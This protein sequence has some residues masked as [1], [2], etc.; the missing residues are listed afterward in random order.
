[1]AVT[2]GLPMAALAAEPQPAS[3]LHRTATTKEDIT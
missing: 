1:M 3:K 2:L